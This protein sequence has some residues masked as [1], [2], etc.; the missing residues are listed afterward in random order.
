LALAFASGER[1]QAA[2]MKDNIA[3]KSESA[4]CGLKAV[5][6]MTGFSEEVSAS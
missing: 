4:T 6:F 5:V 3:A 1:W 2:L